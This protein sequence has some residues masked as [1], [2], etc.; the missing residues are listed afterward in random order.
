MLRTWRG[1]VDQDRMMGPGGVVG[2]WRRCWGNSEG[3][4]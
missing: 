1:C 4:K 2:T 3:L